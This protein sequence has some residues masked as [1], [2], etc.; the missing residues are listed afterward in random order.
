MILSFS[1]DLFV[2]IQNVYFDIVCDNILLFLSVIS[3]L[4]PYLLI[5]LY[6]LFSTIFLN[7]SLLII[8]IL[9]ILNKRIKD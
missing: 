1:N 7:V 5:I 6:P 4:K 9:K 8:W 2:F 3:P